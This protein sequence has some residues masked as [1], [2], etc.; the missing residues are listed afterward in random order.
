MQ[1]LYLLFFYRCCI[2]QL[3]HNLH[4]FIW[5][6]VHSHSGKFIKIAMFIQ[7]GW[8][9]LFYSLSFSIS[10]SRHTRARTRHS[11]AWPSQNLACTFTTDDNEQSSKANNSPKQQQQNLVHSCF[12]GAKCRIPYEP[13]HGRCT[14]RDNCAAYMHMYR[15]SLSDDKINF[16]RE[17]KCDRG[18]YDTLICCPI[19]ANEYRW[20][21]V[22]VFDKCE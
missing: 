10:I 21:W 15:A 13:S 4:I 2:T 8:L 20:V 12:I 3:A 17:L 16:M 14:L 11:F 22:W 1:E 5:N 19:T 6:A 18:Y 7:I 9:S